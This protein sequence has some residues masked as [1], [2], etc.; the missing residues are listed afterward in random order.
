MSTPK[1][2][3]LGKSY[4]AHTGAYEEEYNK[5]YSELVPSSGEA[6]TVHGEML[7][8]ISRLGYDYGNNGNCNVL[9]VERDSCSTCDGSG[10]GQDECNSCQGH[11]TEENEDGDELDC[12]DCGGSGEEDIDCGECGG[13]CE[14]NGNITI[15]DYYRNMV[16]F[17]RYHMVNKTPIIKLEEALLTDKLDY[18]SDGSDENF[19]F[20]NKVTDAVMHQILTTENKTIK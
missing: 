5:L 8:A 19:D 16:D 4:W 11:G 18:H 17:L 13:D 6:E 20:Y 14:T 12:T 7:R 10:W 3:E 9:D 1:I 15:S 2:T